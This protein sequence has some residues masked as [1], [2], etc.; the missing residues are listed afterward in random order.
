MM[1]NRSGEG[2]QRIISVEYRQDQND[3]VKM[4]A[5]LIGV[6][7]QKGVPRL[8]GVEPVFIANP[9]QRR[10]QGVHLDRRAFRLG[11]CVTIGVEHGGAEIARLPHDGG[12]RSAHQ[13]LTHF[14]RRR[15]HCAAD[16]SEVSW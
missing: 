16:N 2:E 4:L 11:D 1:R 12:V 9:V 13:S 15:A 7:E 6:V 3:V 5:I 14:A 10:R 8:D